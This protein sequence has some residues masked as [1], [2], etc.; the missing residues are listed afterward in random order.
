LATKTPN[1]MVL[2]Y[3]DLISKTAYP[4]IKS[5]FGI[6]ELSYPF[7][8]E[9]TESIVHPSI[10]EKAHVKYE[11]CVTFLNKVRFHHSDHP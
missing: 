8:L 10:V 3:Q 5:F 11:Q 6:K 9:K 2:T 4:L 1:F 7:K